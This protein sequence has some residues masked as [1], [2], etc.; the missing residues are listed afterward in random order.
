MDL[1]QSMSGSAQLET[2]TSDGQVGSTAFSTGQTEQPQLATALVWLMGSAAADAPAN[3]SAL[4]QAGAV[5]LLLDQVQRSGVPGVV[6]GSMWALGNLVKGNVDI[7][8]E[9]ELQVR[10]HSQACVSGLYCPISLQSM[11]GNKAACITRRLK[12]CNDLYYPCQRCRSI[13][14]LSHCKR[15]Q[16]SGR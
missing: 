7:Q 14:V 16:T 2:S 13:C 9:V 5:R 15:L 8:S 12:H 1:A 4:H 10:L 11:S 3:Q 6:Q